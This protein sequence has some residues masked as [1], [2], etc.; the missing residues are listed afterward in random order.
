MNGTLRPSTLGEILDRT[1]HLYRSRFLVFFGIASVP[2]AVILAFA[3]AGFLL[4]VWDGVFDSGSLSNNTSAVIAGLVIGVGTLMV[5]PVFLGVSALSSAAM[6]H[7]TARIHLGQASG[8]RDAYRAV[9]QR[10]WNYV[11]LYVLQGLIIAVAPGLVWF[12]LVFFSAFLAAFAGS[13]GLGAAGGF[14][15]GLIAVVVV[16]AVVAYVLYMVLRLALCFPACVVE[17][18]SAIDALKRTSR[19]TQGTRG[20]I[21][22]LY[23]LGAVLNWMLTMLLFVPVSIASTL[24]PAASSPANAQKMAMVM[25]FAFYAAGFAIQALTRPVYGIAMVLFYYDQRI[26][27]EGFDIEWMMLQAGMVAPPAPQPEAAPWL[28]PAGAQIPGSPAGPMPEAKGETR[29]PS[30]SEPSAGDSA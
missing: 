29:E 19:L 8:I 11:G 25:L 6:S 20:R 9:W 17:Q 5:L 13:A 2:T 3:C 7:A 30:T 10:G 23:L 18:I 12:L 21:F 26:R 14:F 4:L 28:P 16:L 27:K 24:I 15:L 22:V 1:A